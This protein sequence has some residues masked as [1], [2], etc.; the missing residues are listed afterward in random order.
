MFTL[1]LHLCH[2]WVSPWDILGELRGLGWNQ[3]ICLPLPQLLI[4]SFKVTSTMDFFSSECRA[5]S[6]SWREDMRSFATFPWACRW[7]GGGK[8]SLTLVPTVEFLECMSIWHITWQRDYWDRQNWGQ[9]KLSRWACDITRKKDAEELVS[10]WEG[11]DKIN[12]GT[13]GQCPGCALEVCGMGANL[14]TLAS[15]F[16]HTKYTIIRENK[17]K[18]KNAY[19]WKYL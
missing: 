4:F 18:K 7:C 13:R 9:P 19:F 12:R 11:E 10:G 17:W 14:C 15:V 2:F 5:R 8:S 16:T 3:S 1:T 6:E